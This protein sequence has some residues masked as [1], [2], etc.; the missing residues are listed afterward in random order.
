MMLEGFSFM[1]QM[2]I[3]HPPHAS[4]ALSSR[5]TARRV[6]QGLGTKGV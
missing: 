6:R 5:D 3:E 2:F 4:I 1:L